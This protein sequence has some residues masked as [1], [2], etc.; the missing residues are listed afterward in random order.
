[1]QQ[2]QDKE[3]G[4][5]PT[6]TIASLNTLRAKREE[7]RTQKEAQP[8]SKRIPRSTD[9]PTGQQSSA[10][11]SPEAQTASPTKNRTTA[12]KKRG[13]S[14][15]ASKDAGSMAAKLLDAKRKRDR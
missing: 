15:T 1:A 8:T 11:T 6:S 9:T 7:R 3:A 10:N 2:A 5:A 4:S 14:S 12:S 13:E